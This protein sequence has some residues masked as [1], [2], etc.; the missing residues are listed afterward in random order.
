MRFQPIK[1][2]DIFTASYQVNKK[3]VKVALMVTPKWKNNYFYR[4]EL[5]TSAFATLVADKRL[6]AISSYGALNA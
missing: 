5:Y 6:N 4:T 3:L 1:S 2:F